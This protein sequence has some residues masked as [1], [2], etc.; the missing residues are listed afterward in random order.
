MMGK[1]LSY[2]MF[3]RLWGY[4]SSSTRCVLARS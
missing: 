4:L 3:I 1:S 2:F